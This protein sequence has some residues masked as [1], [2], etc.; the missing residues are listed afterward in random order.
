MSESIVRP[1]PARALITGMR[2]IGYSFSTAVAD[3][4][5][6]SV[7]A[8]AK[9][10][11]AIS[12]PLAPEPYFCILDNGDGMDKNGIDNALLL[13]SDRTGKKESEVSRWFTFGHNFTCKTIAMIQS[14]LGTPIIEIAH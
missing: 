7:S 2:A 9:E 3:I 6:N 8:N 14:A 12:D 5:D 11:H 1:I 4:F 13:G 10:I